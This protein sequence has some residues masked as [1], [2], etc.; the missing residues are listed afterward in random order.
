LHAI[1][2]LRL[3]LLSNASGLFL[4]IISMRGTRD[5]TRQRDPYTPSAFAAIILV[6]AMMIATTGR[7]SR[8]DEATDTAE[9]K[10]C[11]FEEMLSETKNI[12]IVD[13]NSASKICEMITKSL[14]HKPERNV[15]HAALMVTGLMNMRGLKDSEPDIAY[16]LMNIVEARHI[17]SNDRILRTFDTVWKIFD[18]T[19]GH[20]TPRDLNMVLRRS[21]QSAH[22]L[23]DDGLISIGALIW[24]QKKAHGE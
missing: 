15:F 3:R 23:S 18:G 6:L 9:V 1:T 2:A 5:L 10:S 11:S 20:V 21:G 13:A 19:S 7:A 16:Q 8:A 12:L 14:G 4:G 24:E 17:T 22:T